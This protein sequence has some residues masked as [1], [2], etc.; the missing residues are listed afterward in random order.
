MAD[1]EEK[2]V[3]SHYKCE[4]CSRGAKCTV[5]LHTTCMDERLQRVCLY[6]MDYIA[7]WQQDKDE[8]WDGVTTDWK[9]TLCG[10][11]GGAEVSPHIESINC[12]IHI[13]G[14]KK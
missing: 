6:N 14:C 11:C 3:F 12:E 5:K 10:E 4:A 2:E 1:K 9:G 13:C 7:D 8:E